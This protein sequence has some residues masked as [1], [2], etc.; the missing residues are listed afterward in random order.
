MTDDSTYTTPAGW[1]PTPDGQTRYWDGSAWLDIPYPTSAPAAEVPAEEI[2]DEDAESSAPATHNAAIEDNQR[3]RWLVWVGV[4]ALIII[5]AVVFVNM[6]KNKNSTAT[7][8]AAADSG[9]GLSSAARTCNVTANLA[10]GGRTLTF[11]TQGNDDSTGD[12]ITKVA[13]V[14]VALSAPQSL[15]ADIDATRALDGRQ[16]SSWDSFTASWRYHPDSGLQ[17]IITEQ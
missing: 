17:M 15:L 12:D 1:Y 14:M 4:A 13:C 7:G 5:A 10:D 11:D 9:T 3:P 6:G 2:A 16:E 8:A